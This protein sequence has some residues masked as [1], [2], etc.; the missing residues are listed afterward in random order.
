MVYMQNE[1][2]EEEIDLF[3]L[4]HMLLSRW[5]LI[6]MAVLLVFGITAVYS[7]SFLEDVYTSQASFIVNV[8]E[9]ETVSGGLD[10][11]FNERILDSYPEVAMSAPALEQLRDETNSDY[12]NGQLAGMIDVSRSNNNAIIIYVDVESEDAMEASLIAN[13]MVDV[14]V[15]IALENDELFSLQ[16]LESAV[17][18]ENPSGPN[19]LLYMTI[20][21]ILGGMMGVFGVFVLEFMDRTVKTPKDVEQ[22]LGLRLLGAIPDYE[23]TDKKGDSYNG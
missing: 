4:I 19:R 23:L 6:A 11:H 7:N 17:P 2:N 5:Y 16:P 21:V 14:L 22:K 20:G 8:R 9:G 18:S 3:E 1:Y 15:D 10:A 13:A 12:T